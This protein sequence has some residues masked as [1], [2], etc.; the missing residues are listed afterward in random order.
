MCQSV[1]V[2]LSVFGVGG[3]R[4]GYQCHLPHVD[5]LRSSR[6]S[7]L[8]PLSGQHS[9]R[10]YSSP[11]LLLISSALLFTP[12][13]PASETFEEGRIFVF[14][15]PP[16]FFLFLQLSVRMHLS[17]RPATLLASVFRISD[18]HGSILHMMNNP[19]C[20]TS[21]SCAPNAHSF[22]VAA[23]YAP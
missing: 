14:A 18:S 9:L 22:F 4:C 2:L 23:F 3:S 6:S 5:E 8:L 13:L 21:L 20:C 11:L 19:A 15:F 10:H 1:T 16:S 12:S 7:H 17:W